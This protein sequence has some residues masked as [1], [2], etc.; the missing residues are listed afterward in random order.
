MAVVRPFRATMYA[1]QD[2]DITPLVAPPYDVIDAAQREALLALDP[3][4]VVALELPEGPLDASQ[5][6]NR[7][8][9]GAAR[10][11]RWH[12]TGVLAED[13]EPA[14]Y[15]I[16]QSWTHNGSPVRRRGFVGAVELQPFSAGV[17]LPHERTL[18]KAI[19]DRLNLTRACKANLSQVFGLY[20]DPERATDRIL[21]AAMSV[22]P[23]MVATDDAG[24]LSQVWAI[25]DTE[26]LA[27]LQDL[28]APKQVFIA[29]GHHRYTTSLAYRDE[30]RAAVGERAISPEPAY[31]SVMMMLVNMDDPGLLVLPTHRV[32]RAAGSFD[33]AAFWSGLS[34]CFDLSAGAGV[35][36]L[37]AAETPAFLVKTADG[38][39]RLATLKRDIDPA[40]RID[41]PYHTEWKSLDVAVL[42]ELVLKPLLGIHPDEPATLERL[43][44]I[45]DTAEA[46]TVTNGDVA[47]VLRATRMD[48]L[49]AVALSGDVMPQKSTYF[50]PKLLSGLLMRSLV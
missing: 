16:E 14:L 32:A 26:A 4:N 36:E 24:V 33:A 19:Q 5:P 50:Y 6:D 12:E 42:Q 45:K 11:V 41:A 39:T 27:D 44:F 25:R 9:T 1:H 21:D 48:Q 38:V 31:D 7:Y 3:H 18:P 35:A 20:S 49:R 23:I 10:W 46:L 37:D 2:T 40:V 13:D 15:V 34:A 17:I 29:D 47:F 43:A 30:C 8:Q 22:E 28:L